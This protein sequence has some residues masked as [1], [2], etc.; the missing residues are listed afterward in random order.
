MFPLN[1][2]ESFEI[3]QICPFLVLPLSSPDLHL[4]PL[5]ERGHPQLT[6]E[7]VLRPVKIRGLYV[8]ALDPHYVQQLS[9]RFPR[10]VHSPPNVLDCN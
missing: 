8:L 10:E 6:F 7:L 4:K 3:T 2:T 1:L 5:E 9:L